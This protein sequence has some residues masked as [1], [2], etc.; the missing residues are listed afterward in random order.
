MV[1]G[2]SELPVAAILD[3]YPDIPNRSDA[4]ILADGILQRETD[5]F[6]FDLPTTEPTR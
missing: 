4:E 1:V 3:G 5:D 6:F 2:M